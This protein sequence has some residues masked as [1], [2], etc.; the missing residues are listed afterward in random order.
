MSKISCDTCLDLMPLVED[1]IASKDSCLLV[2]EHIK[3]CES[4]KKLFMSADSSERQMNDK[5]IVGKIKK[6]LSYLILVVILIGAVLGM[7]ITNSMNM[8]YNALIMPL[9][10]GLEFYVLRKN[11]AWLTGG[12][13]LFTSIWQ[14]LQFY[15]VDGVPTGSSVL[16]LAVGSLFYSVIYTFFSI[17]GIVIAMLLEYAFRRDSK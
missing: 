14:F 16:D 6:Q 5:I 1:G 7:M 12:L 13:F 17:I 2:D 11:T 3:T 10:G 4:C 15:I 9:I 8:F